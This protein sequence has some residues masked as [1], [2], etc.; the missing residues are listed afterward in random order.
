MK[1]PET[2]YVDARV[3]DGTP[4]YDFPGAVRAALSRFNDLKI[5]ITVQA[6]TQRRSIAANNYYF[7]VLVEA[8]SEYTGYTKD[9]CHAMLKQMFAIERKFVCNEATGEIIR[10][11]EVPLLTRGMDK[12]RFAQYVTDVESFLLDI[13]A[14][15]SIPEWSGDKYAYNEAA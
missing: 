14:L 12:K 13:D 6:W 5:I 15:T 3:V 8:F 1:L 9:E 7:G 10:E 4:V 11:V 2:M